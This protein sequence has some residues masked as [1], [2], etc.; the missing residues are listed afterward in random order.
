MDN[1]SVETIVVSVVRVTVPSVVVV[2]M[3]HVVVT[4]KLIVVTVVL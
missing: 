4:T 1:G 3:V 2:V